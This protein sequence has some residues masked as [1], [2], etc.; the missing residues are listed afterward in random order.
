MEQVSWNKSRFGVRRFLSGDATCGLCPLQSDYSS[1]PPFPLWD[2][3][4][5]GA[6]GGAPS[7]ELSAKSSSERGLLSLFRV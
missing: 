4:I 6:L 5:M 2:G 7:E 3:I 1:A